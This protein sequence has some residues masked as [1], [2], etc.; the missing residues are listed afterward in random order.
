MSPFDAPWAADHEKLVPGRIYINPP[1]SPSLLKS[2]HVLV[3]KGAREH[4][5]R[6]GIDPL[7]RSAAA[8]YGYHVIIGVL[9]TSMLDGGTV[10]LTAVKKCGGVTVVQDPKT[11]AYPEMPV[12]LSY[13]AFVHSHRFSDR[14][15]REDRGD[16]LDVLEDVRRAQESAQQH[17]EERE[18]PK[19]GTII[20]GARTA[21]AGSHR[22]NQSHAGVSGAASR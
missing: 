3:T 10:G 4:R 19:N 9:L 14:P 17:G 8:T 20:G 7:F 5:Y 16:A 1:D 18:Q 11:A 13:R 21:N 12:P 2:V 15:E 6:P 22:S